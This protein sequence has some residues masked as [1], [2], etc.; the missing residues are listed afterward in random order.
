M[1]ALHTLARAVVLA[2]LPFTDGFSPTARADDSQSKHEVHKNAPAATEMTDAEV[3]KID[4]ENRKLTLKH[5]EIK[6]LDMPSMTMVFQVA[7][8]A[9]LD[10]VKPGDKVRFK[11]ERIGGAYTVTVIELMP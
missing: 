1:S 8:G 2:A 10:R 4:K 6:N 11:A 3:R 7:D 9:M 5:G